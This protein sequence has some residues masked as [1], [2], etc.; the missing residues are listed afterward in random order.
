M[1]THRL[2]Q[3]LHETFRWS[4]AECSISELPGGSF[5]ISYLIVRDHD[6]LIVRINDARGHSSTMNRA[7]EALALAEAERIGLGPHVYRATGEYV[8]MELLEGKPPT[9]EDYR[10]PSFLESLFSRLRLFHRWNPAEAPKGSVFDTCRRHVERR[11]PR[12]STPPPWDY[13]KAYEIVQKVRAEVDRLTDAGEMCHYD[14]SPGN[15]YVLRHGSEITSVRAADYEQSCIDSMFTDFSQ[16]AVSAVA[17]SDEDVLWRILEIYGLPK[18]QVLLRHLQLRSVA[19]LFRIGGH[20]FYRASLA[21]DE[22]QRKSADEII[23]RLMR[24]AATL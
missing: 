5:N 8:V 23:D 1:H 3:A 10:S 9:P 4:L 6:K 20:F 7:F 11:F 18:R 13:M 19:T 21:G 22:V 14:L 24:L 15:V 16:L 17:E 2:A 12:L